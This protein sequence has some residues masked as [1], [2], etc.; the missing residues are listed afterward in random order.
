MKQ[1]NT[2]SFDTKPGP[3]FEY[4]SLLWMKTSEVKK[5]PASV[6][7]YMTDEH[8]H[9]SVKTKADQIPDLS[10]DMPNVHYDKD[11]TEKPP[12][13]LYQSITAHQS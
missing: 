10:I 6:N 11:N 7:N 4:L 5:F 2:G 12:E 1:K 8:E 13:M 9:L 3:M